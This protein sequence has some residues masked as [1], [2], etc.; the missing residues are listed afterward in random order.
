MP[1]RPKYKAIEAFCHHI[2]SSIT[3]RNQAKGTIYTLGLGREFCIADIVGI[4]NV[5]NYS[6]D[7][8]LVCFD[9]PDSEEKMMTWCDGT[10]NRIYVYT[11]I[12]KTS[13]YVK[14]YDNT[15]GIIS[16]TGG[17]YKVATKATNVGSSSYENQITPII[18]F[19]DNIE[20]SN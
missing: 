20:F 8:F 15:T 16:V 3:Y 2:Y 1:L 13:D 11:T 6:I 18:Y 9:T 7:N 17:T 10:D 14:N 4:E 12:T 5:S 19:L